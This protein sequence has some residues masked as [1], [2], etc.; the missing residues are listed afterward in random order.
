MKWINQEAEEI[1]ELFLARY[2]NLNSK[3][4]NIIDEIPDIAWVYSSD[5]FKTYKQFEELRYMIKH[6]TEKFKELIKEWK[7]KKV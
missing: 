1:K 5:P 3:E 2:P 6:D 7:N 4:L